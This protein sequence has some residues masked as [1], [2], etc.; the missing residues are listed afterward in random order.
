MPQALQGPLIPDNV[1]I[2]II[3]AILMIGVGT[4]VWN[5]YL[6]YL[7]EQFI[8]QSERMRNC[9]DARA[10]LMMM[11]PDRWHTLAERDPGFLLS[12]P[13]YG[14]LRTHLDFMLYYQSEERVFEQTIE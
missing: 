11:D 7:H 8:S 4:M 5:Y 2:G 3:I 6:E 9:Y 14:H 12:D 1:A 13:R 10:Q